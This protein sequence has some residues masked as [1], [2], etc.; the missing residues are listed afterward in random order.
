MKK[1]ID[2]PNRVW[3]SDEDYL[4]GRSRKWS[5]RE[6]TEADVHRRLRIEGELSDC[7]RSE[8][9]ENNYG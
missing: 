2:W 5:S 6:V 8:E 4:P 1:C 9:E 3:V 7:S